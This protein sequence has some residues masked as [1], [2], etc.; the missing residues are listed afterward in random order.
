MPKNHN[1]NR[2]R[3]SARANVH[4]E[5]PGGI[6]RLTEDGLLTLLK[7]EK[8]PLLLILDGVQDPHNLGACLR[9]ADGA[10]A[11]AVVIPKHHAA[12]VTDTVVRVSCGAAASVP[13][14]SVTN[15]ARF[16]EAL[17]DDLGIRTVGTDDQATRDLYA[18]DLTGPLALVL[19]AEEKGMRRLTAEKCDELI[20]IPMLGEVPCLNVSNATAVCLYE[21]V[22]QRRSKA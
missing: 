19:G 22:R 10:G 20:T 12:P 16:M 7:K 18:T 9:T 13:V 2:P 6:A 11:I 15:L 17:R 3:P 4:S 5:A 14:V 8:T 21:A 1:T